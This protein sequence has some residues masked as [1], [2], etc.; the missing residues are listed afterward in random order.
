MV[1]LSNGSYKIE[2]FQFTKSRFTEIKPEASG[3]LSK[4]ENIS[5]RGFPKL[6][7][8]VSEQRG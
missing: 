2:N 4:E 1:D 5:L 7:S 8:I 3:V 6:A